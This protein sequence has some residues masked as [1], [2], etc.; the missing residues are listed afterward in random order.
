MSPLCFTIFSGGAR[1]TGQWCHRW[2]SNTTSFRNL[3]SGA[4]AIVGTEWCAFSGL[5]NW[6][7]GN[8]DTV[9]PQQSPRGYVSLYLGQENMEHHLELDLAVETVEINILTGG[10]GGIIRGLA[11]R[12]IY[13]P[14]FNG[15]GYLVWNGMSGRNDGWLRS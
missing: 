2:R 5:Y 7:T 6:V 1:R 14:N 15:G 10:A 11:K 9:T 13:M 4:V 12:R 8:Y 3:W